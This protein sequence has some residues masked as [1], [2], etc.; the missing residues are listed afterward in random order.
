MEA[1]S[2][3]SSLTFGFSKCPIC[4]SVAQVFPRG[5]PL[6]IDISE[7]ILKLRESGELK[8][9]QKDIFSSHCSSSNDLDHDPSL[10]PA[11]FYTL[12]CI[13]GGIAISAL[14]ITLFRQLRK[15]TQVPAS[16][17]RHWQ[18]KEFGDQPNNPS[19]SVQE[20]PLL[21]NRT[22]NFRSF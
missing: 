17:N 20:E 2:C 10:G 16:N 9:L 6:V 3:C 19:F 18:M 13:T 12:F 15:Q 8:K 1:C 4:F 14:L 21:K 7:A 5:S 11:P 22:A